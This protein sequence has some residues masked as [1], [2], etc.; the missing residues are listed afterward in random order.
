MKVRV[1]RN[2]A[3]RLLNH[4]PA[5]LVTSFYRGR[6]NVATIAWTMPLDSDPP[7]IA[8]VIGEGNYSFE[9]ITKTGDFAINVPPV[10]LKKAVIG[11]GSVSGKRVDKFKKFG[12]TPIKA[13]KITAPLI[14]ECI[15][16]LECRLIDP[17]LAGKYNL[18]LADVVAVSVT[19]GTF[20][21]RWLVETEGVKTI[22]HLGGNFFTYPGGL[23]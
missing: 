8:L 1:R 9:C 7:R 12:L 11:A 19:K 23:V 15:G 20:K 16:H 3:K 21:E 5:V 17:D 22:H 6:P 14:E 2:L 4:G 18:F 10:G 13:R